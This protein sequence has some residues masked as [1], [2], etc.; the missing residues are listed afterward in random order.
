MHQGKQILTKNCTDMKKDNNIDITT[1]IQELK[2]CSYTIKYLI[3]DRKQ[4]KGETSKKSKMNAK[5]SINLMIEHLFM[6]N[7]E[8]KFSICLSR[9]STFNKDE[10]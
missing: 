4:N 3:L 10:K 1:I 2:S 6:E 7:T 9:I 8:N 5:E